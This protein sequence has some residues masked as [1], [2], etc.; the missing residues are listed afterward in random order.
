MRWSGSE[1]LEQRQLLTATSVAA[2]TELQVYHSTGVNTVSIPLPPDAVSFQSITFSPL[3]GTVV[4]NSSGP[5]SV[6][7]QYSSSGVDSFG[8][9]YMDAYGST[10][11]QNVNIIIVDDYT[12]TDL[13]ESPDPQGEQDF[14]GGLYNGFVNSSSGTGGVPTGGSAYYGGNGAGSVLGSGSGGSG[15]TGGGTSPAPEIAVYGKNLLIVDGDSTPSAADDTDYG[16]VSSGQFVQH[17]F[18]VSNSGT[19]NLSL[20]LHQLPAGWMITES[21]A[22][23]LAPGASDT[24]TVRFAPTSSGQYSTDIIIDNNDTDE[25]PYNFVIRGATSAPEIGVSGNGIVIVDGDTTP[26]IPDGTQFG[27]INSGQSVSR[28][29]TVNNSGSAVLTLQTPQL[30]FGFTLAEPL[31]SQL[32]AGTSDTFTVNFSPIAAGTYSGDIT[33]GNNDSDESPYNFA[34][35]GSVSAP[36]IGVSGGGAGIDDGDWTPSTADGTNF[37]MIS[38]GQSVTRTFTVQNSGSATLTLQPPQLPA[39]FVLTESLVTQL[40]PGT[41]DTFSVQFSPVNPGTYSGEISI[42]NNDSNE[43]PYNFAITGTMGG[44]EINILGNGYVIVDGDTIPSAVDGTYFGT[45]GP[46]QTVDHTFIVN[47]TGT[48]LLSLSLRALPAGFL[49]TEPLT[50]VLAAGGT[51]SFTVRFAPEIVG[52]YGGE[53]I[54]DNND[55]DEAPYNFAIFGIR[56]TPEMDVRG[57]GVSIADG[58]N[59]PSAADDTYFGMTPPNIVASRTFTVRN[60]G[61]TTLYLGQV[62]LGP[63]S[64]FRIGSDTLLPQIGPGQSDTFS[65]ELVSATPGTFVRT[66]TIYNSDSDECPYDFVIRGIVGV[67]EIDLTGKGVSIADGDTTPSTTDDTD[68]GSVLVSTATT[69]HTLT[70]TFTVRNTGSGTLYL[71]TPSVTG[72]GFWR[73][74]KALRTW[75]EPGESDTFDVKFSSTTTGTFTGEVILYNSDANEAPY[76][77]AVTT[78][79]T[80]PEIGVL[81]KDLIEIPSG[82]TT[83]SPANGTDYGFVARGEVRTQLFRITN[84]GN[85]VLSLSGIIFSSQNFSLQTL[86]PNS[87]PAGAFV[88]IGVGFLS[89][90]VGTF[91]SLVTLTNSDP[92]ESPYTFAVLAVAADPE[93][94]VFYDPPNDKPIVDGS[95]V[96]NPADGTDFG[97]LPFY[98]TVGVKRVFKVTNSG[99]VPLKIESIELPE[100]FELGSDTLVGTLAPSASDTFEIVLKPSA[101]LGLKQGKV[102]IVN[103][104]PDENPYD[105]N[106]SGRVT[107]YRIEGKVEYDIRAP[108]PIRNARITATIGPLLIGQSYTDDHGNYVIKTTVTN[109]EDVYLNLWTESRTAGIAADQLKRSVYVQ[110]VLG[111]IYKHSFPLPSGSAL[112]PASPIVAVNEIFSEITDTNVSNRSF[113]VYDAALTGAKMHAALPGVETGT[114]TIDF[115]GVTVATS[116]AF[117]WINIEAGDWNDWDTIIHEY[118]HIVSQEGGFFNLP[119]PYLRHSMIQNMRIM[120]ETTDSRVLSLAFNEGYANFFSMLAQKEQG[121]PL[122]YISGAGDGLFSGYDVESPSEG[123]GEDNELAVMAILW[124][125]YDNSTDGGEDLISIGSDALYRLLT[126]APR[127][128]TLHDLR[129]K[130]FGSAPDLDTKLKYS[131]IFALNRVSP[132]VE[133]AGPTIVKSS[134]PVLNFSTTKTGAPPAL[135]WNSPLARGGGSVFT[136]FGIRIFDDKD[137]EI[138]DSGLLANN[139]LAYFGD[140]G[141]GTTLDSV[142][143]SG[144]VGTVGASP[145]SF[146]WVVYGC[147]DWINHMTETE[148]LSGQYWS[149]S[150]EIIVAP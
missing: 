24:F 131:R 33:I 54:I 132:K 136:R 60:D 34:I 69:T 122:G 76:N 28:T 65:V 138:Y 83:S 98:A 70:K 55:A 52:Q 39:G 71:G 59:T 126:Q 32:A 40:A 56:G 135:F 137:M 41:S 8:L 9:S 129:G 123:F 12:G 117:G 63:G 148:F 13:L 118:D 120:H 75:L 30:P 100:G 92:D 104:D 145:K 57:N 82:A 85:A 66:V 106:I 112:S 107:G 143:W 119:L 26:A 18:T 99:T 87:I 58:D 124:D 10:R 27:W 51:D 48:A 102:S 43:N 133:G 45:V 21:L 144:V 5:L 80:S 110:N 125:L 47:N 96:P 23:Y 128:Y 90:V 121:V 2:D 16:I 29:F 115:P 111:Q 25:N 105:F 49:L 4:P 35:Q 134:L 88:D 46:S 19:A 64:G 22:L 1:L 50:S 140:N 146:R 17:T 130:L 42:G 101:P 109:L 127:P 139:K 11:T 150:G 37:G 61:T 97:S 77:F 67:P 108:K 68:F 14:L 86:L 113:W 36:E 84:T 15:G 38:S 44:P 103:N 3:L 141:Y 116:W 94:N 114:V 147:A 91:S 20:Q 149:S 6:N 89:S 79:V 7:Y 78:M 53:I 72:T 74:A 31:A 95:F 73:G 62:S 81:G 142:A 93:M